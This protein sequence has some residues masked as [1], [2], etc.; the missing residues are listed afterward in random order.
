[1]KIMK[2]M[3]AVAVGMIS[4]ASAAEWD[5]TIALGATATSGNSET[6]GIN[7]SITAE[8][9]SDVH[10]IRLGL[11]LS[12]AESEINGVDETTTDNCKLVAAYKYK[13]GGSYIY[14]D[15]SL[16]RD[17]IA[18]VD[19][20]L[21]LG[22]GGGYHVIKTERAKLGLELGAAYIQ[23]ELTDGSENDNISARLAAR[24]DQDLNETAKFWLAAEYLPNVDDTDDYLLNGEIG[25]EAALNTSLSLRLV[26]QDRY[27]S[28][29]PDG[30]DENDV[31][32]VSSF[33][34][35]L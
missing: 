2:W 35:K 31:S 10:E 21:I 5:Q 9:A 14:S 13:F 18:A 6:F 12:Y 34:Y 20:R 19:Y 25:V 22:A 17:D 28:I 8:K 33:V 3:I 23:E 11:D 24:H 26:V 4:T 32:L 30:R 15:N 27:D 29:V 16:L 7:G 1:M